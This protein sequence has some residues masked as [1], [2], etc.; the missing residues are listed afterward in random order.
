MAVTGVYNLQT[1]SSGFTPYYESGY[2]SAVEN[3][4]N[5]GAWYDASSPSGIH[6]GFVVAMSESL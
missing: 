5:G 3:L 1:T 4:K 2:V 6:D